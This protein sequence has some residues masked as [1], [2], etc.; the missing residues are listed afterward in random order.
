VTSE[1]AAVAFGAAWS[2]SRRPVLPLVPAYL[3]RSAS[4]R[5]APG[6][7]SG[8]AVRARLLGRGS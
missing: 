2:R 5:A 8:A 6:S 4:G 3:R 1:R 7:R